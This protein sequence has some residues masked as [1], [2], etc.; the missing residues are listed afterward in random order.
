[1]V[2]A[3]RPDSILL[4]DGLVIDPSQG[5]AEKRHV[6][7]EGGR[8]EA[9]LPRDQAP[10]PQTEV[11]IDASHLAVT[12]GFVD[13]HTHVRYP[14]QEQKETVASCTSA[15]LRGGF[16]TICAMANTSPP[17]D[18]PDRV[19][20]VQRMGSEEGRCRVEVVGAATRGL[21]GREPNDAASL[22]GAGAVALSDDGRPVESA[23]IM[24]EILRAS[25]RQGFPVSAHEE[26]LEP[27]GSPGVRCWTCAGEA[28][29]IRRDLELLAR[30]GGRLHIAHV[31][32]AESVE[33]LE[34]AQAH[35]L[36]VTGEAS[37]HHLLLTDECLAGFGDLPP[38]HGWTKVSPPLRSEHDVEAV[39]QGL[40]AGVLQAIATDHA[41]HTST[42]KAGEFDRAAVGF[43]GLETALSVALELVSTAV[44]DLST[45]VQRLTCGPARIFGLRAGTLQPGSPASVCI[46]D[47]DEVWYPGR[48][49][50][51]SKS[52]NTPLSGRP[53]RG[54]VRA[55]VAGATL[56]QF[57]GD[58][59][60]RAVRAL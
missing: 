48:D 42:D 16:T 27:A 41:P 5:L 58:H 31:S 44:L 59:E 57:S 56:H 26:R 25:A 6:H 33:L 7:V 49:T 11:T 10:L 13:I 19:E 18:S 39:R 17:V 54:R 34:A 15:A 40:A 43:T 32:C 14:G 20:Q 9:I 60:L 53:L 35:G 29:M 28:D 51:L 24:L 30:S 55:V 50:L 46:F 52:K 45:A 1:M 8:I 23:D 37:P 4:K 47:P 21:A 2:S 36:P 3:G 12:P 22:M 38:R